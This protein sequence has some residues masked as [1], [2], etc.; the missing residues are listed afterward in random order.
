MKYPLQIKDALCKSNEKIWHDN[1]TYNKQLFDD[2]QSKFVLGR[3]RSKVTSTENQNFAKMFHCSRSMPK[4]CHL[5]SRWSIYNTFWGIGCRTEKKRRKTLWNSSNWKI[6]IAKAWFK[7]RIEIAPLP[8]SRRNPEIQPL[9]HY[10]PITSP[11][12]LEASFRALG[13]F[14]SVYSSIGAV[15]EG[16]TDTI[17]ARQVSVGPT[18][19]WGAQVP[20][21][22][23]GLSR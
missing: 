10:G 7:N 3:I 1:C 8:N 11:D 16:N 12:S 17:I 21:E 4:V 6:M 2:F 9:S 19:F 5:H 13:A 23:T 15:C 22:P 14:A 18:I 20:Q